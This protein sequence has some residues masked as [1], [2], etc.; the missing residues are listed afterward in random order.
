MYLYKKVKLANKCILKSDTQIDTIY[1][2]SDIHIRLRQRHSEYQD[3][4]NRL[5]DELKKQVLNKPSIGIIIIT[6]DILHSK[7]NLS[8]EAIQMTSQF[9]NSL[10][11]IMPTIVI[12]GNHDA[13]LS[14]KSRLDALSP[15][16]K[17][18]QK[19]NKN[20]FYWMDSGVY[21]LCN[22]LFGVT[23]VFGLGEA[24]LKC[25]ITE[26]KN[27][28]IQILETTIIDNYENSNNDENGENGEQINVIGKSGNIEITTKETDDIR[29]RLITN[30][31]VELILRQKQEQNQ[32][33]KISCKV[34][35]FHETVNKTKVDNDFALTGRFDVGDF[36]GYDFTLLGDIH[37]RQFLDG[38]Y[39]IAYSGSLVQQ[40]RGESVTEHGFIRWNIGDAMTA[41]KGNL[42][43][44]PINYHE[45]INIPNDYGF[46]KI[47]LLESKIVFPTNDP[48]G[49]TIPKNAH[50]YVEYDDSLEIKDVKKWV[51]AMM[52]DKQRIVK[53]ASFFRI[54]GFIERGL[55]ANGNP[56]E[57]RLND[58]Q[59]INMDMNM[60]VVERQNYY[61]K[62]FMNAME[63]KE[64]DVTAVL[65]LNAK[66]N[67][68]IKL[69]ELVNENDW[70]L[71]KLEFS[72]LFSYGEDNIIDFSKKSGI[73]GLIAPN[74]SGKSSIIDIILYML[75]DSCSRCTSSSIIGN[76]IMNNQC[77]S[78]SAQL[79]FS[80]LDRKFLIKKVGKRLIKRG[81][82]VVK[83]TTS[84]NI[85]VNFWEISA[86]GEKVELDGK[87]R[88]ETK[89]IMESY[90]GSYEDYIG[91][92]VVLQNNMNYEFIEQTTG[93]RVDFLNKILRI[94]V[95]EK[96]RK[97]AAK[98]LDTAKILIEQKN[99]DKT[100]EKYDTLIEQ[101]T[102]V[103]NG[104]KEKRSRLQ[105]AEGNKKTAEILNEQIIAKIGE[106]QLPKQTQPVKTSDGKNESENENESESESDE[107]NPN[108][109]QKWDKMSLTELKQLKSTVSIKLKTLKSTKDELKQLKT[110]LNDKYE[111]SNDLINS[112]DQTEQLLHTKWQENIDIKLHQTEEK[113]EKL[114]ELLIKID[115]SHLTTNTY[116]KL[117]ELTVDKLGVK[118]DK[119]KSDESEI[120][121]KI[122]SY[123]KDVQK[124][125]SDLEV[126]TAANIT[127]EIMDELETK[128]ISYNESLSKKATIENKMSAAHILLK[129]LDEHIYDT[130]CNNCCRNLEIFMEDAVLAKREMPELTA[131]LTTIQKDINKLFKLPKSKK[132]NTFTDCKTYDEYVAAFR[133]QM[134]IKSKTIKQ[135]R[136][137]EN[138]VIIANKELLIIQDNVKN[139][140]III[141]WKKRMMATEQSNDENRR[142]I[143]KLKSELDVI[144][145][146]KDNRYIA[147]TKYSK[148]LTELLHTDTAI[149]N[150]QTMGAK[151]KDIL[152]KKQE[153]DNDLTPL[154]EQLKHSRLSIE[155]ET[156]GIKELQRQITA[157]EVEL[158]IIDE[159][160]RQCSL[161]L[162]ELKEHEDCV[163]LY[164]SYVKVVE[165]NGLPYYL[166]SRIIPTL[167]SRINTILSGM[168]DFQVK[169]VLEHKKNNKYI[170]LYIV[171]DETKWLIHLTSGFEK[172]VVNL[173][174]KIGLASI[175]KLPKSDFFI[176]DEGFGAFDAENLVNVSQT[177]FEYLKMQYKYVLIISHIDLMKDYLE[178]KIDINVNE[179]GFSEI[180]DI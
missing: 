148:T 109:E 101:K 160:L 2:V 45:F 137:E 163:E 54:T 159:K 122:D 6:G 30:N 68:E 90:I 44:K 42:L 18:L 14:N 149:T 31:D 144:K 157:A 79:W 172:F 114:R 152:D 36:K 46:Y 153:I 127:D 17:P 4:F 91:T 94:E 70:K 117:I 26:A 96:L 119:L 16:I 83:G 120:V 23:S 58:T 129:K 93:N 113:I 158:G 64:K 112:T 77:D 95:F 169:F 139:L 106:K 37:K 28:K 162:I 19:H 9:L 13:N 164:S 134:R 65:N 156:A 86:T 115:S 50:I 87:Q 170:H 140:S 121:E 167:E 12:A 84:V 116:Y 22:I 20:L 1:H 107:E 165:K 66:L 60:N 141:E 97:I 11:E 67:H 124:Y 155:K 105:I 35:L 76:E 52:T 81:K 88:S 142:E 151:I 49:D 69:D 179:N 75:F 98:E 25:E 171:R 29:L 59:A 154:L 145:T 92:S 5:Y 128:L 43:G 126:F 39:N 40:N 180:R 99:K 135:C 108:D 110:E 80:I 146:T 51:K 47:S 72:N 21:H 118:L 176:I 74:H 33:F 71:Q 103:R 133:K 173:A 53:S 56:I 27:K 57:N 78:F 147:W 100:T 63:F 131:A 48:M 8:P 138:K 166:I 82:A 178:N 24:D 123:K 15:I 130:E 89:K 111:F 32:D 175:S 38:N 73:Y 150:T 168:V 41:N 132:S 10:S 125:T 104:L 177:L 136:E 85:T 34:S 7:T 161:T 143:K 61:M 102:N 62:M 55:D 3:V 174:V